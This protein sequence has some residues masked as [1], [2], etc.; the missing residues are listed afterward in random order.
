[1]RR[2]DLGS[3]SAVAILAP[4]LLVFLWSTGF[5]GAKWGLPYAEPFT[6]SALRFAIAATVFLGLAL[7][8]GAAW[9][10]TWRQVRDVALV[11]ILLQGVYLTGVF[12]A[13]AHGTPAW[14]AALVAGLNPLLTAVLAGPYLGERVSLRQWAGFALGFAGVGLVL[15]QGVATGSGPIAGTVALSLGLLALSGGTLYQKRHGGSGDLRSGQA[16]QATAS[17]LLVGTLALLFEAREIDWTIDFIVALAWLSVVLSVGMFTLLFALIRRGALTRVSSLFFLVPPVVAVETH[18]LFGE[19]MT[20][21][22]LL[23]M[24][25]AAFGVALVTLRIR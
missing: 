17:L 2:P 1:M 6:L 3:S 19:V 21:R 24:A 16:V 10:R 9:P 11:G 18:L 23:G 8:A 5:V 22:D 13:I 25:L 20:G 15:W 12:W 14:M 7:A 4:M